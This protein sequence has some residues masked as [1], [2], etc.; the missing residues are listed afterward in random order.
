MTIPDKPL[1]IDIDLADLTLGELALFSGEGFSAFE[2]R[3]FLIDK[4]NWPRREI[5]AIKVSEL[6]EIAEQVKGE[7][8]KLAVPLASET[9]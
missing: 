5:N 8:E 9:D 1:K 3:E 6:Q 7:V 4:T 2:F